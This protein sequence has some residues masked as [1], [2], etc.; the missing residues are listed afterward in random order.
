MRIAFRVDASVEVGGGHVMR[1]LALADELRRAG[2]EAWF[3][4]RPA[5]GDLHDVVTKCWGF[6]VVPLPP[7]APSGAHGEDAEASDAAQMLTALAHASVDWVVVDHYGLGAAWEA[8]IADAGPRVLAIDDFA[9]RPH[10]CALVLD[11]NLVHPDTYA[12][13]TMHEAD[14][15]VGP[16]YALLRAE[17]AAA[18]HRARDDDPIRCVLISFGGVDATDQTTKAL[19]ALHPHLATLERVIVVAGHAHPNLTALQATACDEPKIEVYEHVTDL[20]ALLGTADLAIGAG[21]VSA[22]ERLAMGVP[23][24]VLT[25]AANQDEPATALAEEGAL[26][27]LGAAS[28]VDVAA[29]ASAIDAVRNPHLRR[30]MRRRGRDLVD[31]LGARRVVRA[32]T[33][34]THVTIRPAVAADRDWM[35]DWRND[36]RVRAASFDPSEIPRETHDA[37]FDRVSTDP[38]RHLLVASTGSVAVGVVR[39]D[40]DR[41]TGGAEASIYLAPH[42]LGAGLGH[43]VLTAGDAWVASHDPDVR[44]IVAHVRGGNQASLR[45]FEGAGY[46]TD[47]V[48]LHHDVD[49][50]ATTVANRP[51]ANGGT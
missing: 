11:H 32:M 36:P 40:V 29:I 35:H 20:A 31:G 39:Y 24:I 48:T 26:L 12:A 45:L 23:T 7:V 42:L 49:D 8:R 5:P 34:R 9:Q 21:G 41:A 17:F 14:V 44:R 15:L 3:A 33:R 50:V 25:T 1:C 4:S 6:D 43:T 47:R 37:W 18:G 28:A 2:H 51:D 10:A 16:R 27:Y 30:A 22:L 46:R 38:D 13:S 19:A